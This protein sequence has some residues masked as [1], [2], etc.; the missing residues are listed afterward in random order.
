MKMYRAHNKTGCGKQR[1][2]KRWCRYCRTQRWSESGSSTLLPD[3]SEAAQ[4]S[5]PLMHATTKFKSEFSGGNRQS[6]RCQQQVQD[7]NFYQR[8][9]KHG[10]IGIFLQFSKGS[11]KFFKQGGISLV[12]ASAFCDQFLQSPLGQLESG[13][14]KQTPNSPLLPSF[15]GTTPSQAA[16][17]LQRRLKGSSITPTAKS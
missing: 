11:S 2:S 1:L 17:P 3:A 4:R 13:G 12:L 5:S 14:T 16:Q 9:A 6:F 8:A 10:S 15:C 7:G